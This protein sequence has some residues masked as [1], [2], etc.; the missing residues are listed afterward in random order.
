MWQERTNERHEFQRRHPH[1]NGRKGAPYPIGMEELPAF[2]I[3]LEEDVQ[4][5]LEQGFHIPE[6]VTSG[7]F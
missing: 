4:S 1:R 5:T 7:L 2:S 3:W 6:E